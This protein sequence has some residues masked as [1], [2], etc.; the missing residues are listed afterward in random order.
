MPQAL[1]AAWWQAPPALRPVWWAPLLALP[2]WGAFPPLGWPLL[3][4]VAPAPLIW[5]LRR[6]SAGVTDWLAAGLGLG[7]LYAVLHYHW[8][9]QAVVG[10]GGR[11]W[12]TLL[13]LLVLLAGLYGGLFALVLGGARRLWLRHGLHPGFAL[14]VLLAAQDALLG[15]FPFGGMGWG[16]PAAAQVHTLGARWV[17]PLLGGPGVVLALGLCAAV[18]AWAPQGF[19]RRFDQQL[20][21][22]SHPLPHRLWRLAL[23]LLPAALLT[24]LAAWPL[25][26][27]LPLTPNPAA[28]PREPGFYA[29]PVPGDLSL[30]EQT[31]ADAPSFTLR[32]YLGRTLAAADAFPPAQEPGVGGAPE[33][34]PRL[35]IWPESAVRGN[36]QGGRG[37]EELS[38]LGALLSA[39]FLL[40]GDA[41]DAGR[42]YNAVYLVEG[43]RPGAR[44]YDKRTLVPFGEVVPAG[45]GL[46]VG[47]S[48]VG[49]PAGFGAGSGPPVLE[50]RGRLLGIAI[51]SE[52]MLPGHARAAVRR[53]A[54]AIVA[55]TNDVWLSS[56]AQRQHVQLSALRGLEVGRDVLFVSNGAGAGLLRG[57]Q[58]VTWAGGKEPPRTV[59]VRLRSGLTPWVRAGYLW[60]LLAGGALLAAGMLAARRSPPLHGP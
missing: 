10:L 9:P 49:G 54:Q 22:R 38:T 11:S 37:L 51:C 17:A 30:A 21:R 35:I 16:S 32:Y 7:A 44:R 48:L 33:T 34:L 53:G 47:Q 18:W 56:A 6:G 41:F 42:G 58:V 43:G 40:G 36:L 57:G 31:G 23:R 2:M 26:L 24:A 13:E 14:P 50:W 12:L 5:A 8:L 59:W 45:W 1:R 3:G 28:D 27:P 25:T 19:D 39:D 4:W 55:P 60:L 46:L 20:D 52:S 29:L 15:V